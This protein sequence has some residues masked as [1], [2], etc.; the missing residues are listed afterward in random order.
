V[1]LARLSGE[2]YD[3]FWFDRVHLVVVRF[4]SEYSISGIIHMYVR[5]SI[6]EHVSKPIRPFTLFNLIQ[7]I[8]TPKTK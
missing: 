2:T 3:A 7:V 6:S 1:A 5:V 8:I 4:N